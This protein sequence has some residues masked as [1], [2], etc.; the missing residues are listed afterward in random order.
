MGRRG[1]SRR[2]CVQTILREGARGERRCM[3]HARASGPLGWIDIG[4]GLKSIWRVEWGC[5]LNGTF[6]NRQ[7]RRVLRPALLPT[8]GT[9]RRSAAYRDRERATQPL[10][11]CCFGMCRMGFWNRCPHLRPRRVARERPRAPGRAHRLFSPPRRT[12]AWRAHCREC[13]RDRGDCGPA[14]SRCE[15]RRAPRPRT[16]P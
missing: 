11:L 3:A 4:H 14:E 2:D 9:L 10:S 13:P 12:R 8:V 15:C 7:V 16:F 1:V 6:R 5:E